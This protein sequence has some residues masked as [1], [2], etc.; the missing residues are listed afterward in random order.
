[1]MSLRHA[2]MDARPRVS[3]TYKTDTLALLNK[4]TRYVMQG[5]PMMEWRAKGY[6]AA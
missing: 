6:V 5:K 3:F 1:M 4:G 2:I